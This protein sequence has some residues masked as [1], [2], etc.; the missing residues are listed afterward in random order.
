MGLT[1]HYSLKLRKS[2]SENAVKNK[3]EQLRQRCL[4]L[5]FKEVGEMVE[6]NT[7]QIA[8]SYEDLENPLRWFGIQCS[9]YV[10][11]HYDIEG[12]LIPGAAEDRGTYSRGLSPT[13][14]IGFSAWPGDGSE[15][16]NLGLAI[17]PSTIEI[18]ADGYKQGG[19]L[20]TKLNGWLWSSFCKTQYANDPKCGGLPN[21]LRCHLTVIAMLDAAKELG[22]GVGVTDEGDFWEKRDV[23]ALAA[24]IGNWDKMIA[25]FFGAMK[26][27]IATSG[28]LAK[29]FASAKT[30]TE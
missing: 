23:K 1:I 24:E 7:E 3:L 8:A 25:G 10:D 20:K 18:P 29:M 2:T 9:K 28:T 16:A 30:P 12:N 6:M 21:F 11:Y 14:V 26:D 19:T 15:Q 17:Y 4:D 5:P 13:R 22:F 27:A